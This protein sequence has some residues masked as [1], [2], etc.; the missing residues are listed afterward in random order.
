VSSS[1][2]LRQRSPMDD[3]PEIT[4]SDGLQ[5]RTTSERCEALRSVAIM[6][7]VFSFMIKSVA[8][9]GMEVEV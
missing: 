7:H 2:R 3:V 9:N 5:A 6:G 1:G 8:K 4:R